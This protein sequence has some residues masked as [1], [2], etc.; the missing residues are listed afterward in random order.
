M[1]DDQDGAVRQPP[2]NSTIFFFLFLLLLTLAGFF[3]AGVSSWDNHF[4]QTFAI[5]AFAGSASLAVGGLLGF[6]F[7]V[8]RKLQLEHTRD[9]ASEPDSSDEEGGSRARY[10]GNTNLEQISDWLTKI[11]IGIGLV[12]F[13]PI[14]EFVYKLGNQ[15]ASEIAIIN[16]LPIINPSEVPGASYVT[17][18]LVFFG[19]TGFFSGY[20][21]ARLYLGRA[22][23][24][25]ENYRRLK[26]VVDAN[27]RAIDLVQKALQWDQSKWPK[28][29]VLKEALARA[30]YDT[31]VQAFGLAVGAQNE[32]KLD[33]AINMFDA[34][35]ANNPFQFHANYAQIGEAWMSKEP[36][37]YVVAA[38][39][40]T[41]AINIRRKRGLEGWRHYEAERAV[42][43]ILSD[44]SYPT[45]PSE[46][47]TR[48]MIWDDIEFAETEPHLKDYLYNDSNVKRW[49]EL[50]PREPK[51]E[52][53]SD[54]S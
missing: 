37:D 34:L 39:F 41:D 26:K 45:G 18:T 28:F 35:N 27:A 50:N 2:I 20:L 44:S 49:T 30:S 21:W 17:T 33:A 46:E 32:R 22:F 1:G 5:L 52:S 43:R 48:K 53:T 11:I 40:L 13:K 16:G 29:E 38:N 6:L 31:S 9:R 14:S 10:E 47:N 12:Q 24:E 3:L 51:A 19:I 42:C 4:G 36:A 8:P 7:G 15:L 54:G 23:D 25:A